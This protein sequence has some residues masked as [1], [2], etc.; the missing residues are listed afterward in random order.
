MGE[1]KGARAL[2]S[3]HSADYLSCKAQPVEWL[4]GAKARNGSR[5]DPFFAATALELPREEDTAISITLPRM[6]H[7]LNKLAIV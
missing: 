7:T 1:A 4:L 6:D 2:P 5:G 3:D